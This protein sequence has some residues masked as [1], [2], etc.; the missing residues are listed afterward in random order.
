MLGAEQEKESWKSFVRESGTNSVPFSTD[1]RFK[2]CVSD[3][4]VNN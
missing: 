3:I 1:L 2:V 4:G